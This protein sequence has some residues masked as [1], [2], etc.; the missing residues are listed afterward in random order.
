MSGA[1][2][3]SGGAA[4]IASVIAPG[5]LSSEASVS[6]GAGSTTSL[7]VP[8]PALSGETIF[9]GSATFDAALTTPAVPFPSGDLGAGGGATFTADS[10]AP[11]DAVATHFASSF[12]AAPPELAPQPA[13]STIISITLVVDVEQQSIIPDGV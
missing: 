9:G 6:G 1:A 7:T 8:T 5:G 2:D 10:T 11:A 3:V 4:S 12:T 13:Q